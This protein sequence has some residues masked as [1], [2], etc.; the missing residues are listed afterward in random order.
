MRIALVVPGG[1]DPSAEYRVIP[2]L[3]ALIRRLASRHDVQVF[4][5]AQQPQPARWELLGAQV[6]NI[7]ARATRL[8]AVRAIRAAHR[9]RAFDIIHAIWSG[10]PGLVAVAAA[11]LLGLPSLVHV[12]GGELVALPAI[13]YGGRL[14]WRGRLREAAVL[15]AASGVSAASGP[16]LAALAALGLEA[17]LV[18]LGVDLQCWP[19]RRPLPRAPGAR[20]RLIHVASL[21]RVKD[22]PTLLR[23]LVALREAGADFELHVVGADTL[24][25]EI[26]ALARRLGLAGAITFH[27][28][29]PQR[30][31]RPLMAASDLLLMSSLHEAGPV[32]LQEAGAVGVPAVGTAVGRFADWAPQAARVVPPGDAAALAAEAAALL[33][34][35]P[36]R[37]RLAEAAYARAL[38]ENADRTAHDFEALYA[39]LAARP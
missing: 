16:M 18:P 34:D 27:G 33:R 2:V 24:G 31:L 36:L 30:Q 5:L 12:A 37:L 28:F 13:A 38:D 8:G 20:A 29:V 22:Q 32:V 9:G 26:Q 11:R 23:A 25:G 4:A 3:L 35:E 14:T 17:R 7:G 15:R 19:S 6:H 39:R 10:S 21:N 1:V